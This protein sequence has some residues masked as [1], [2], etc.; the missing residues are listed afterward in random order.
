[1][2]IGLDVSNDKSNKDRSVV[3]FCASVIKFFINED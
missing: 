2:I 3:A 1:M